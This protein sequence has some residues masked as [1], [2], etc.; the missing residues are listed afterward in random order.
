MQP[1]QLATLANARDCMSIQVVPQVCDSSLA[2]LSAH[3]FSRLAVNCA[4]QT[5]AKAFT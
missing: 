5:A 4:L 1:G 3:L 2:S